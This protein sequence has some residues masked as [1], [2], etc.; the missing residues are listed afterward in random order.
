VSE[1]SETDTMR[2]ILAWLD[3]CP[4][5]YEISS[6]QGSIIHIKVSR[7]QTKEQL[8]STDKLPSQFASHR[9]LLAVR[10]FIS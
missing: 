2:V 7:E 9:P 4:M 5:A 10:V 6:M 1:M 3:K 8:T